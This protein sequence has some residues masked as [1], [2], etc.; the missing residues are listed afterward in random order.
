MSVPTKRIDEET[1]LL[2]SE[3]DENTPKKTP[4]PWGQFSILLMLQLAEPLTSQLIYPFLPELVREMGVTNGDE[5]KVGF[6]VGIMQ[7]LFF[8]IQALTVLHWSRL[9]D[10]IGRKP[11]I[12][13]G[14]FGISL[15][16]YSFGLSKT[17]TTVVISR[18][19]NGALNGNIGVL[20]SQ[21]ASLFDSSNMAEAYA[22]L[23]LAWSTGSTIGPLIGG[24]LIHPA[25]RFPN[26]FGDSAFLREYPYFLPCAVP[27]TFA[28]F[29]WL[30]SFF[31]LHETVQNP[32]SLLVLA[33]LRKSTPSL[34]FQNVVEAQDPSVTQDV[35]CEITEEP[36]EQ[37]RSSSASSMTAQEDPERPLPLR[38]LLT[39]D[40]IVAGGNYALLSLVDIMFRGI[41]PLFLSTP[42]KLGGLG[43]APPEI[44]SILSIYGIM[45]GIFQIFFFAKINKRL[46][47]KLTFTLGVGSTVVS[48]LCFP[49][50]SVVAAHR[51]S[52]DLL[53]RGLVFFQLGMSMATSLAYGCIFI[54]ITAASPNQASLGSTNGLCQMVVSWMRAVG[55]AI[56]N[57]LYSLSL[58]EGNWNVYYVLEALAFV[59]IVGACQL[60][61]NPWRS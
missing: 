6:F 34:V 49:L 36:R 57:S 25:E 53:V 33:G 29:A 12:L 45:N 13:T 1:P 55:P 30:I 58:R 21:F 52:H 31:F 43:L 42:P 35:H 47:T 54:F 59:A 19:L 23:P 27:A 60:P 14:L 61:R 26:I 51:G 38:E 20:K 41:L 5:T 46:G 7:S 22:Y 40:V 24:A 10:H 16:M 48:F 44:G 18:C 56:A 9:S 3:R 15:S 50:I 32:T 39:R 37:T 11:V 2:A 8:A 17:F 28:F 4:F